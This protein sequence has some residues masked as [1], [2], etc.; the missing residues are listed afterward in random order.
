ML[1]MYFGGERC[2]INDN[3]ITKTVNTICDAK[4]EWIKGIKNSF[5]SDEMKEKY[6]DVVESRFKRLDI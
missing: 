3:V 2:G 6:M 5:L 1:I 4:P